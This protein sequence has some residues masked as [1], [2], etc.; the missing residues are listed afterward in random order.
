ME[1]APS[2]LAPISDAVVD[3]LMKDYHSPDDL[4]GEHGILK[5]LTKALVERAMKAELTHHLGYEKHAPAGDL[6]GNSRNGSSPKTLVG[7]FGT[8]PID[9]P[10][11]R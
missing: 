10:R 2:T 5:R 7:D 3:E 9:V 1:S 4:R 8:M 11:D 6:S